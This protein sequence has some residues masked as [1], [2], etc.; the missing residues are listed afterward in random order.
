MA[1]I[2]E[3]TLPAIAIAATLM[4]AC[5]SDSSS[6]NSHD[7]TNGAGS[8]N[9]SEAKSR[10]WSLLDADQA[11]A[12]EL[13]DVFQIDE[14]TLWAVGNGQPESFG[15]LGAFILNS[16]DGGETWS[17]YG[18][19]YWENLQAVHFTDQNNGW[20][21]GGLVFGEPPIILRTEDAGQSW[22]E[23]N[24]PITEEGTFFD[25]EFVSSTHGWIAG[26]NNGTTVETSDRYI[27]YTT[28]GGNSWQEVPFDFGNGLPFLSLSFVDQNHGWVVGRDIE[29]ESNDSYYYTTDGGTNWQTSK[30]GVHEQIGPYA[31]R[32]DLVQFVDA[33]HGYLAGV[34]R[35]MKTTDGG[36]SWNIVFQDGGMNISDIHFTNANIGWLVGNGIGSNNSVAKIYFTADGGQSWQ[37]ES[38]TDLPIGGNNNTALNGVHALNEKSVFAVGYRTTLLVRDAVGD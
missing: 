20:I 38:V 37:E 27:L 14:S 34:S 22:S 32:F 10:D 28:N 6:S 24:H 8:S 36:L 15:G 19:E 16:T 25:I 30:T 29:D 35:L 31:D 33:N 1:Y 11:Q 17:Q 3:M 9:L 18:N 13:N 21:V 23:Q 4:S 12:Y 26:G 7:D 2:K 5:N